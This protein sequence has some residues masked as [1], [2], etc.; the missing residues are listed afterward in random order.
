M[1]RN[2]IVCT[3]YVF[4][5]TLVLSLSASAAETDLSDFHPTSETGYQYGYRYFEGFDFFGYKPSREGLE[6]KLKAEVDEIKKQDAASKPYHVVIGHSQG[7]PRALGYATYIKKNDPA[8]YNRLQAV[9]TMS[10]IDK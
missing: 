8:E 7:G 10:G 5:I 2:T 3:I 6:T 4:L 9:I 1:K